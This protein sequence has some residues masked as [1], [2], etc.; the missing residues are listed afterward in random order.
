MVKT[1]LVCYAD[2]N[3]ITS[4]RLCVKSGKEK[5]GIDYAQAFTPFD[6]DPWFY[7]FNKEILEAPQRG[8][9]TGFWLFKP[10]FVEQAVRNAKDGEYI[11]Y[12]D[13]GIEFI[14][15][16]FHLILL[17]MET[18]RQPIFL[19]GNNHQHL[20]WCKR[21]VARQMLGNADLQG[22]LS[23]EQVQ[24]SV[25]IIKVNAYTRDFCKRWLAWAQVPGMID[26][27]LREDQLQ[28]V[29]SAH[30]ND[31]SILTNLAIQD[32]IPL[33]WWPTQYGHCIKSK[34]PTDIYPQLFYHHRYRESDW[35]NNGLSIEAFMQQD[36]TK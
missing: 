19:F 15:K 9:G 10:Y 20:A 16:S 14:T 33:H 18:S 22:Y 27:T 23:R 13:S 21:E 12:A 36:K 31:Q 3:M 17:R 35:K 25:I 26:D 4:Q 2:S 28:G 5:A 32:K 7:K 1:T 11:I 29:F 6:F 30:R 8:G 24:A 34:Y